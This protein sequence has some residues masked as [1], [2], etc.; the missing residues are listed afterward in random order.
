MSRSYWSA[1]SAIRPIRFDRFSAGPEAK[2]L[3]AIYLYCG[4]SLHCRSH[5]ERVASIKRKSEKNSIASALKVV[6]AFPLKVVRAEESRGYLSNR[7]TAIESS[8]SIPAPM[9]SKP[10]LSVSSSTITFADVIPSLR[11]F[12]T[13]NSPS[14]RFKHIGP[15]ISFCRDACP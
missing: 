3:T 14:F 10:F 13:L 12:L 15:R 1:V 8:A 7:K 6:K 4:E 2:D 11:S 9:F 5:R